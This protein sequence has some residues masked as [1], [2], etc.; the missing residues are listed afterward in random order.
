MAW[1]QGFGQTLEL[2]MC[3]FQGFGQTLEPDIGWF[4]GP[5]NQALAGSK[6]LGTESGGPKL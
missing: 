2:D 5:W 6:D 3:W 1:F 4:Q